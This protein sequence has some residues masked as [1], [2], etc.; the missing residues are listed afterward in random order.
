MPHVEAKL[1]ANL[2]QSHVSHKNN[3]NVSGEFGIFRSWSVL[4][5]TSMCQ[6]DW[7]PRVSWTMSVEDV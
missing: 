2:I 3:K 4:M 6:V 1:A 5:V 7:V